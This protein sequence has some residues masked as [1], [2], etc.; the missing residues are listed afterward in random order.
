VCRKAF[1]LIELLVV[2]AIIALL[3]SILMPSLT[4]AKEIAMRSKCAVQA[5]ATASG[6]LLYAH[7]Y[8]SLPARSG[9][10]VRFDI[11]PANMSASVRELWGSGEWDWGTWSVKNFQ[12]A[13]Y[14][15]SASNLRCPA[16]VGIDDWNKNIERWTV[17]PGYLGYQFYGMSGYIWGQRYTVPGTYFISADKIPNPSDYMLLGCNIIDDF[18]AT[19]VYRAFTEMNWTAHT[20]NST[21]G[22]NI[23]YLDTSVRWLSDSQDKHHYEV[24]GSKA[25]RNF[26]GPFWDTM[27]PAKAMFLR[28]DEA[29]MGGRDGGEAQRFFWSNGEHVN[30]NPN[31]KPLRGTVVWH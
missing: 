14:V 26:A 18:N 20:R 27:V 5:R 7:D 10:G 9:S 17:N 6:A 12:A 8:G 11:A 1:T 22:A 28:D 19:Y 21:Q 13:G 30:Q 31:A 16:L 4:K 23:A 29:G 3:V 25:Q 2:I 24:M 15:T